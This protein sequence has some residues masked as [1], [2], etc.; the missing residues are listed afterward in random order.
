[1]GSFVLDTSTLGGIQHMTAPFD[2][3]GEFRDIQFHWSQSVSNQ[4][5]ELHYLELHFTLSGVDAAR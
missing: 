5:M 4:D 2:M 3:T 1:M